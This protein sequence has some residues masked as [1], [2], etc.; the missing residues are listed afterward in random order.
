MMNTRAV[1]LLCSCL[2]AGIYAQTTN[3]TADA[4]TKTNRIVVTATRIET[5]IEETGSSISVVDQ[6]QLIQQQPKNTHAAL[7]QTSG[8]QLIQSGGPG[9]ASS[10]F[11][12]GANANHTLVLV[13]GVRVNSNTDGGFNL[14]QIPVDSIERIEVLK[15]TQSALYGADAIGGVV[16]IITKKGGNKPLSGSA[17][18]AIGE[19]G[20]S[21]EILTLSGGNEIVDFMS[22]LSYS[23]LNGYDI[24]DNK[25]NNGSENDPT[26]RLSL[27]NDLGFNFAEDGRA[28]LTVLYNRNCTEIDNL[29]AWPNY[30]QVDDP[31]RDTESEQW[32]TSLN[33][34]KPVTERYTQ[35]LRFSYNKE[36]TIG[37][38]NGAQDY[39]FETKNYGVSE[40]SDFQIL[41]NDTL[42]AGYEFRRFEAEN[43][44]SYEAQSI[45]QN[46]VFLSNHLELY[47]RL[48]VTLGTRFD[49]YSEFDSQATW[50]AAASFLA[51]ENTRLHG[52]IGTGYKVPT[53][54][55]LYWPA[56]AWSAGNPDLSP[57][58]SKSFDVGVEQTLLDG[59]LIAD[60]TYFRSKITDMIVWAETAPWFWQPSNV[61]EAEI[62]GVELSLTAKPVE[63]FSTT[64]WYTLTDAQDANTGK[65][66]AR[67]ARHTAG[68][69][70]NWEYSS[71]GSVFAGCTYT[72]NRY[73]DADNTREMD[74]FVTVDVGTRYKLTDMFSVFA[75][76]NNLFDKQYE[77]AAGYGTIGRLA[78]A[79]LKAEF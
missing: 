2:T 53:M 75:S 65:E 77:T 70:A 11:I 68:L 37:R 28:D 45:D 76:V 32:L 43:S 38:D 19:K 49:H 57:E 50:N 44:G 24:A 5:P 52:N 13:N 10:T 9:T 79:G 25:N 4:V 78:S 7:K 42:S 16:N 36:E 46:S 30:W 1:T 15:G 47:E 73:D 69:T 55:D 60:A 54:N 48:F 23:E 3:E 6:T 56:D 35:N 33:V 72:G 18:T 8:I 34:S 64:A 41:E 67:R 14:S 20:Y 29:G 63:D 61:N 58:K 39:L 22:S 17:S 40:Q 26:R 71:K 62:Q 12:R 51:L 66:L 31:D 59:K 21:E 27:F 74:G